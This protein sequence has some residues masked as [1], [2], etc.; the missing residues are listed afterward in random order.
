MTAHLASLLQRA[1]VSLGAESYEIE[2]L[3]KSVVARKYSYQQ[4]LYK[5]TKPKAYS[6]EKVKDPSGALE[7]RIEQAIAYELLA[8]V[9][10]TEHER[11]HA[12]YCA[13]RAL[14]IGLSLPTL[15][16]VVA[17]SYAT[18]CLVE[19][20]KAS[21][22]TMV[23]IY[24]RRAMQACDAL[25]ELG[26]LT[27]TLQAA[28]VHYAG[29]AR[30]KDAVESLSRAAE[31]SAQLRDKRQWEEC[32]SHQVRRVDLAHP[33]AMP[34]ARAAAFLVCRRTWS[35]T[36]GTSSSPRI[37]TSKPWHR[38]RKGTTSRSSTDAVLASLA[39]CSRRSGSISRSEPVIA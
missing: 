28:G 17:R 22:N 20:A 31:Y 19:S 21:G 12:G 39:C 26:Q 14:N 23:R 33:F 16:P 15:H 7:R 25:G 9:S 6:K 24:K 1:L 37:S 34:F 5:V 3:S 27:Y 11:V 35:T 18:L 2:S 38:L 10:M 13:M 30:W 36:G 32:I 8:R 4:Y 29:N